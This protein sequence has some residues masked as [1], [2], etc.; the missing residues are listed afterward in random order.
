MKKLKVQIGT[1][2]TE[3]GR[4][5][6]VVWPCE[7]ITQEEINALDTAPLSGCLLILRSFNSSPFGSQ[8]SIYCGQEILQTVHVPKQE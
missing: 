7:L 3:L 2:G 1:H 6:Q 4:A 8:K 5:V